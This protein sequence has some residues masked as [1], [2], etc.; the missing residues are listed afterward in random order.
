MSADASVLHAATATTG[1]PGPNLMPLWP[2]AAPPGMACLLLQ[3]PP[4]GCSW[5]MVSKA[6]A[7]EEVDAVDRECLL[8]ALSDGGLTS[9]GTA[10]V[11]LDPEWWPG[12]LDWAEGV[13]AADTGLPVQG[14]VVTKPP[15]GG[16]AVLELRV[17]PQWPR[18][19]TAGA[20]FFFKASAGH[21]AE[22][23]VL[24]SLERMVKEAPVP[25]QVDADEGR[26]CFLMRG[27][28]GHSPRSL[29][30]HGLRPR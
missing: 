15:W 21:P 4:A 23:E 29:L 30:P 14:W 22:A 2:I 16:S 1:A 27:R 19:Q 26:G 18:A 5:R 6:Q 17:E 13:V 11:W 10:P 12:A 7:L 3:P 24:R 28:C 25:S 9:I 20:R 8:S